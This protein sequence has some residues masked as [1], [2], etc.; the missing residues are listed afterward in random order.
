MDEV[1]KILDASRA[2]EGVD[3]SE[4]RSMVQ[5]YLNQVKRFL[6]LNSFFSS[7]L[8]EKD[9]IEMLKGFETF[10]TNLVVFENNLQ[11]KLV[12]LKE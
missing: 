9:K 4:L 5:Y 6:D 7:R 1:R 11:S 8:L 12:K 2:I 3:S 10:L